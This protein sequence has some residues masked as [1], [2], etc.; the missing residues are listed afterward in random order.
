VRFC[1][2][3][4]LLAFLARIAAAVTA[5]LPG[6]APRG[7]TVNGWDEALAYAA[8]GLLAKVGVGVLGWQARL[9]D[10]ETGGL[11]P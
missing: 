6:E 8:L 1:A 11:P 10:H 5:Y 9:A 7:R 4:R 2:V 3:V